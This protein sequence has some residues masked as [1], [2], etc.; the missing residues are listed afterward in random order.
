MSAFK[1]QPPVNP[2]KSVHLTNIIS[3]NISLDEIDEI[4]Q[5]LTE[6][7]NITVDQVSLRP[8]PKIEPEPEQP[9]VEPIPSREEESILAEPVE[10]KKTRSFLGSI[11]Y[12]IGRVIGAVAKNK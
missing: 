7:E 1:K 10:D 3:K 6:L 11:F 5:E 8:P 9:P 4:A 2:V 12:A